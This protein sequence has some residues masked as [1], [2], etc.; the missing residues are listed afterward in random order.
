MGVTKF[1]LAFLAA[2]M[3]STVQ[4]QA[5]ERL[6]T[7]VAG[8]P[9]TPI[10]RAGD[11]LYISGQLGTAADGTLPA[12][13]E[14]QS[15]NVMTNIRTVAALGGASMDDIVKCTVMIADMKLWPQF[16]AIY[17]TFFK[18]DKLPARSAFGANGLA[19]GAAIEVECIAYKPR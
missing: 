9:F 5:P 4:A 16:N 17:A 18:P 3:A 19:L 7:I 6:G 11:T 13:F 12:D 2:L 14:T 1:G 8:R 15:H 10:V